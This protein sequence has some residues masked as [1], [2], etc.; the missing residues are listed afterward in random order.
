M[1]TLEC[2]GNADGLRRGDF[3][4]V[5]ADLGDAEL[6]AVFDPRAGGDDVEDLAVDLGASDGSE[7]AHGAVE[8]AAAVWRVWSSCST[9]RFNTGMLPK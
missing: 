6:L 5:A 9:R 7:V 8:G 1:S 2:G 3:D 4:A